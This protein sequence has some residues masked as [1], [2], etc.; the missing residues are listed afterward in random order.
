MYFSRVEYCSVNSPK[1]YVACLIRSSVQTLESDELVVATAVAMPSCTKW[2]QI[3]L[4]DH[5]T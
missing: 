1:T 3:S 2:P 4:F 5:S